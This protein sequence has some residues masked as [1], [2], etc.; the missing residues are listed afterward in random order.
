M[1]SRFL[2]DIDLRKKNIVDLT[3]P[4]LSCHT[5]AVTFYI[6]LPLVILEM[7]LLACLK[8]LALYSWCGPIFVD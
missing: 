6:D 5:F 4:V 8:I 1:V 3:F 7:G 2:S